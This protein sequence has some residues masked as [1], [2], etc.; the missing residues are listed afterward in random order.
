MLSQSMKEDKTT[1]FG[2]DFIPCP[3]IQPFH[4]F[5]QLSVARGIGGSRK[6]E[7]EHSVDF[8]PSFHVVQ[9]L[10]LF[11]VSDGKRE[12]RGRART[13]RPPAL[14]ESMRTRRWPE[15]WDCF[16]RPPFQNTAS[17]RLF[18]YKMANPLDICIPR[19]KE[20]LHYFC[21]FFCMIFF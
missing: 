13:R 21:L 3:N 9:W 17:L 5:I 2:P 12:M 8:L 14:S 15:R 6:E 19:C 16:L 11:F 4:F 1:S 20:C 10:W 18:I 7:W